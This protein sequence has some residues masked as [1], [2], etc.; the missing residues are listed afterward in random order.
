M[1]SNSAGDGGSGAGASSGGPGGR[2]GGI[3]IDGST[4]TLTTSTVG[5]NGSGAGGDA[6]GAGTGGDGGVGGAIGATRQG[7]VEPV[8][9]IADTSVTTNHAGAAG[10]GTTAG[11]AGDGGGLFHAYGTLVTRRSSIIRNT[12]P[13][14]GGGVATVLATLSAVNTTISEN[15]AGGTGGGAAIDG[16]MFIRFSTIDDN[17]TA[18]GDALASDAPGTVGATVLGGSPDACA[19]ELTAVSAGHNAELGGAT[20]ALDAATD[21]TSV[22]TSTLGAP[23]AN[24]GPTLTQLPASPGV[25]VARIPTADCEDMTDPPTLLDQRG[26][27]RP[28]GLCDIGAVEIQ[29]SLTS[30]PLDGT[31]N[32]GSVTVDPVTGTTGSGGVSPDPTSVTV[33]GGPS[34]GTVTI[35]PVTG[36]ITYTPDVGYTGP[37]SFTYTICSVQDPTV[38][39]SGVVTINVASPILDTSSTSQNRPAPIGASRFVALPP[40]RVFDTREPG[41]PQSGFV[42]AGATLNVDVTGV[43]GI[44]DSGVAAVVLNV[45]ATEAGGA[46][47][48][49]VFPTGGTMPVASA[50]NLAESGHTAPNLVTVPVGTEGR[51]SFFTQSGA[52]LLADVAGYFTPSGAATSGRFVATGPTRVFDTREPGPVEG[53]VPP[54]GTITVS[55]AGHAGIPSTSVAAVVLNVTVA[56]AT[57]VGYVTVWPAGTARPLASNLNVTFRGQNA[58]N[59]VVVPLGADGAVS[60][61]T[62]SGGH[63]LADVTG[64][65]TGPTAP[66]SVLGLFVPITPARV[67]DTRTGAPVAAG[68]SID[69]V[70]TGVANVPSSRVAGLALNV[71]A[72]EATAPGF[73]TAWPTGAAMPTASVLNLNHAGET[74]PNATMISVGPSGQISYFTQSGTHLLVDVSGYF[75][76]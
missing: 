30:P 75:V 51:V 19:A 24:G 29:V 17:N 28:S 3:Y 46:G 20:C 23:A 73:V 31:A 37:D 53:I 21:Q 12:A 43:A 22:A 26:L 72:T 57:D 13:G 69:V 48:V 52:H 27:G 60:L 65:F 9:T 6:A 67:F 54:G 47:Y 36:V 58:P 66:S 7:T 14:D 25:L 56:A 10:A 16:S 39:S 40:A 15:I 41:T 59:L 44:P 70:S 34:H 68:S 49:T 32:G 4:L 33:T 1:A 62:Q 71:T 8:V 2:G 64:Y 63:L 74:R 76:G 38:C 45:T 50:L 35:D 5:F 11:A 42:A 61:F 18:S 55:M